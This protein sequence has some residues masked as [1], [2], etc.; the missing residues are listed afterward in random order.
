MNLRP[1]GYSPRVS[2]L[3]CPFCRE[4]FEEG[5]ATACPVCGMELTKFD[6]LPPS[7]DAIHDDGGVPLSP[8]HDPLPFHHLGRGKGI[9]V[10]LAVAGVVLFFLPWVR[11]TL[12]YIDAKSGFDLAHQRIGWL[13][14]AFVAWTV[15]IPTVLSRRTIAQLRGAR[16]AAAFL[17]AIP[18][19]AVAILLMKPPRGSL[20]PMRYT[21]DWPI[22]AVLA[23]SLV[24][25]AF[26]IRLGGRVDDIKVAR[27]TSNGQHLH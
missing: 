1:F 15:L 8:E 23:V 6:K 27:G 25:I 13:W 21:W 22:Y 26:A 16:V 20:V 9:M 24:A 11:L 12:P 5:E 7:L 19:V 4:M 2:L 17:G 14:A 18:A 3:A 10:V